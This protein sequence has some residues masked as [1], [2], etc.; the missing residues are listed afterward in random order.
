MTVEL[1]V[2]RIRQRGGQV[3]FVRYP[4]TGEHYEM[5]VKAYP[6]KLYWDHFASKTSAVTIHFA[7]V[8]SLRGFDCPDTAHLDYRD[9]PRFTLA[10]AE[11]LERRAVIH[12]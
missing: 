5:D 1:M 7:D 10:L 8:P 6:K 12:H 9:A 11:E 4:T 2:Q 3:V